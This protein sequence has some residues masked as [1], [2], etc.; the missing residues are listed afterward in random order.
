MENLNSNTSQNFYDK[1]F[2]LIIPI[3]EMI[4]N[5]KSTPEIC[6]TL[7]ISRQRLFYYTSKLKQMGYIELETRD[8]FSIWN[9]TEE[10]QTFLDKYNRNNNHNNKPICRAEHIRFKASVISLP[11]PIP[12]NWKKVDMNNWTEYRY[13]FNDVEIKL[14]CGQ[15]PTVEFIMPPMEDYEG[16]PH[17]IY[18]LLQTNCLSVIQQ[19]QTIHKMSIGP[20]ELSSNGEWVV[21]DPVA[22]AVSKQFN[23]NIP[24]VAKIN[25]S[26]PVKRGEFEFPTPYSA[27]S[28]LNAIDMIPELLETMKKVLKSFQN[29][30]GIIHE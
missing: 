11:E 6:N 8:V 3:L 14:N 29:K 18:C 9:L 23:V 16:N 7:G 27:A 12:T 28:Y 25:A 15:S 24:G 22:K 30:D 5:G 19:I 21:Y 1:S 4:K 10:G 26:K 20:I 13:E 2:T 17:A